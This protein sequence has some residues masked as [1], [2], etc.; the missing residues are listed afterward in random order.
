MSIEPYE[1][2]NYIADQATIEVMKKTSSAILLQPE[3]RRYFASGQTMTEA[4]INSGIFRDIYVALGE[5]LKGDAWAIRVYIKPFV[6]WIWTGALFIALGALLAALDR[7][8][9]KNLN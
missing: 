5:P 6:A 1:G 8:Y 4:S 7:R 9:R 3:K 2:E